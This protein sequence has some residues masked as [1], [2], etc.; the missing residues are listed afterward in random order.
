MRFEL[1]NPTALLLSDSLWTLPCTGLG[2]WSPNL[3]SFLTFTSAFSSYVV[4]G[5]LWKVFQQFTQFSPKNY[6]LGPQQ[7]T[8]QVHLPPSSFISSLNRVKQIRPKVLEVLWTLQCFLTGMS[9]PHTLS[10]FRKTLGSYLHPAKYQGLRAS[11]SLEPYFLSEWSLNFLHFRSLA[12]GY[13][14]FR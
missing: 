2:C 12:A 10:Y 5:K 1:L 4:V 8:V 3:A 6:S 13:P 7:F 9:F 14:D 11:N